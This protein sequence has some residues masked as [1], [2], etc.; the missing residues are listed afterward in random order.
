MLPPGT[1]RSSVWMRLCRG[2]ALVCALVFVCLSP[3]VLAQENFTGIMVDE[4]KLAGPFSLGKR[5]GNRTFVPVNGVARALGDTVTVFPSA[6]LVKVQR[7]TGVVAEFSAE[8]NQVRENGVVVLT[9]TNTADIVFA[10]DPEE[11]MLPIEIVG[12]LLGVSILVDEA[13]GEIRISRAESLLDTTA[14]PGTSHGGLDLYHSEYAYHISTNAGLIFQNLNTTSSGRLG[15]GR[16]DF[17]SSLAEGTGQITPLW[18]SGTFTFTRPRGQR[19]TAGNFGTGMDLQFMSAA[20][21]GGWWEQ[22]VGNARVKTF[23]GRIRSQLPPL[24]PNVPAPAPSDYI[25]YNTTVAGSYV[26]FGPGRDS[27]PRVFHAGSVGGLYFSGPSRRG[28]FV[29]GSWRQHGGRNHLQ[30][31]VAAGRFSG[32]QTDSQPVDGLGAAFDISNSYDVSR[33][34]T[35][36]ARA[37]YLTNNFLLPQASSVYAGGLFSGGAHWRAQPWLSGSLT[38][39]SV[40][41]Q[42]TTIGPENVLS[43]NVAFSRPGKLP[44][45]LLSHSHGI[46]GT[47][48]TNTI[49]NVQKDL[50]RL[51]AFALF[52]RTHSLITSDTTPVMNVTFG[53]GMR[54]NPLSALQISQSFGSGGTLYGSVDYQRAQLF[55]KNI[56]VGLGLGYNRGTTFDLI[57]R[58]NTSIRLPAEQSLQFSYA[59]T[60][61]GAQIAASLT[62]P[63]WRNR[64]ELASA[65]VAELRDFSNLQGL[66]YEDVDLNAR[67]DAAVDKPV[68]DVRLRLDSVV[69]VTSDSAGRYRLEGLRLG[70]HSLELDLLSVRADLTIL[71]P[72]GQHTILQRGQDARLDFRVVR[73][74]GLSGFVWLDE[75]EDGNFDPSEQPL[76]DVRVLNASGRDTLT[77]PDG[78][79]LLGDLPPGEHTVTVD[80][81]SLPPGVQSTVSSWLATVRPAAVERSGKFPAKKKPVEIKIKEF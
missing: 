16:F 61:G 12:P 31:D 44:N 74:G 38:A 55:G 52:T 56:S 70:P 20:M 53:G 66:V 50:R 67:F 23:A 26:T 2:R 78:S 15:D 33:K 76:V 8:L 64:P 48:T 5:I 17:Q 11:L 62:G 77:N 47:R 59:N 80:E 65:S 1:R 3:V 79:F 6:R 28:S 39:S 7:Q 54:I 14:P 37:A 32:W 42:S 49:V 69:L 68:P 75:D 57:E 22:P 60:T 30:A 10:A 36:Q 35:L 58:F 63:L 34:L 29:T 21:L 71:D 4:R 13:Q 45:I 43:S 72:A 19:F 27:L 24:L 18:Q 40:Q 25:A 51:S 81:K 41:R 46:S 9:V 73:T